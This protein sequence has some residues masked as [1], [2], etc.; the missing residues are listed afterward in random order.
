MRGSRLRALAALVALVVLRAAPTMQTGGVRDPAWSP[1]GRRLAF[2]FLDQIWIADKD[3]GS[4]R[5]LRP[6]ST[7]VERQPAWSPDG[8]SIAFA[9]DSGTGYVIVV[10]NADGGNRR[11]ISGDGEARWPS[12]TKDGR[13][14]F[15]RRQDGR[16]RLFATAL[17]GRVPSPLFPGSESEDQCQASVSPDGKRL[18][19]ISN[20]GSEDGDVDLWVADLT[21]PRA[22]VHTQVTRVR[23]E[24]GSPSWA[25]DGARIAFSGVRDGVAGVWVTTIDPAAR[26]VE[27]PVLVSRTGGTP[28]WSPDGRRI[29]I[30]DLPP[31]EP[32]YNGN[33]LRNQDDPP[34]L[35][36]EAYRLR[37]VDAPLPADSGART[38]AL[39]RAASGRYIASFDRVWETLRRLYYAEGQSATLWLALKAKYRA[40]AGAARLTGR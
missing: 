14:I 15:S 16:W 9:E 8:K 36:A 5:P 34:P 26:P 19:Y 40:A 33:P 32:A 18:A 2:S 39:P 20:R 29:A 6:D 1:D 35:F 24:E 38:V 37:L 12:W 7:A 17:D 11:V 10:L 13:V 27:G 22:P 25:P 30:A 28:A 3:G 31:V 23:G 21:A 4:G